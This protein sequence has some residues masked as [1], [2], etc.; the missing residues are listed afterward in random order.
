VSLAMIIVTG[1]A[2]R[3]TGSGLGCSDW[4][5]CSQ[6]K[7]VADLDYHPMIEFLNR[8]FT[9]AV[10]IFVVLAVLGSLVRRPRRRDL[11]WWSLGLVAG[12]VGQIVLG[13]LVVLFELSPWLVIA[14]FVPS[15]IL[16]WNGVVLRTKAGHDGSP[17]PAMVAPSLVWLG[18][19]MVV[20]TIAVVLSGT[21]VTGSGPHGGDENV[22]RLPFLIHTVARVHGVLVMSLLALT[23]VVGRK[24][25]TDH[26]SAAIRNRYITVLAVLVAQGAIGY[27]QYFTG[28][29]VLLV[30][31]H[32]AGAT[33]LWIAMLWFHFGLFAWRPEVVPARIA[34]AK[35]TKTTAVVPT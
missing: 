16:V 9:G 35:A 7:F 19:A 26:A 1:A 18:R 11:T 2:V 6:D 15:M 29:P 5:R 12:V 14:H 32:I 22:E 24:L 8:L 17:A 31:L 28:V 21:L 3:L 34:P 30:G 23:L 20:F 27:T 25:F 10:S 13:G 33:A 4:P